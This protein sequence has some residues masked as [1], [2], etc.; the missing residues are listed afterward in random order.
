MEEPRLRA[1]FQANDPEKLQHV[2]AYVEW[3]QKYGEEAFCAMQAIHYNGKTIEK[4]ELITKPTTPQ[5]PAFLATTTIKPKP[6][7]PKRPS[8][9]ASGVV[10][11][12]PTAATKPIP[13][14]KPSFL[15]N[16]VHTNRVVIRPPLP[17]PRSPNVHPQPAD[18]SFFNST[19]AELKL[20]A[21]D[22]QCSKKRGLSLPSGYG[23]DNDAHSEDDEE[24]EDAL[25]ER[26]R[27]MKLILIP[28]TPL[29][30]IPSGLYEKREPFR[31][32]GSA[33][34]SPS[35]GGGRLS[36]LLN[37]IHFSSPQSNNNSFSLKVKPPPPEGFD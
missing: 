7:I 11:A 2:A 19:N 30:E 31:S 5:P 25:A 37:K 6:Q 24:D 14:P 33:R 9:L 18:V 23:E 1:F 35:T 28:T 17:R 27:K 29:K 3:I 26:N 16:S 8:F 12:K 32:H 20:T 10:L 34:S 15:R 21:I 4:R 13:P 36:A 22:G